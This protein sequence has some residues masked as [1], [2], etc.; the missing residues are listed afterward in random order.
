MVVGF[1]MKELI[2]GLAGAFM[3]TV[4]VAIVEP[5]AFVAVRV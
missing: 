2:V 4:A 1:A 3:V 5:V